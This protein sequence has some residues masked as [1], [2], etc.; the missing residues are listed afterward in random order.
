MILLK[1]RYPG[2]PPSSNNAYFNKQSGGRALTERAKVWQQEIYT[3]V[4]NMINRDE[5]D[6][7]EHA[8]HPLGIEFIFSVK[9][10]FKQDWDGL[11]KVCQDATMMAMELDDKYII[12]A[13]VFKVE[14]VQPSFSIT[15][16]RI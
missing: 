4:K 15:V 11:V 1:Y 6:F 5:L 14:S 10:L 2:T 3:H 8:G 7:R 12:D 16:W 13:H 9:K